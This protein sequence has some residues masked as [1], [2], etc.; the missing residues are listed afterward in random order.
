MQENKHSDRCSVV[1]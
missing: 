1:D